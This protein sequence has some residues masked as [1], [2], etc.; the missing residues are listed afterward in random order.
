MK[1]FKIIFF[2]LAFVLCGVVNSFGQ[3]SDPDDPPG[4][5]DDPVTNVP[6][7]LGAFAVLIGGTI[8]GVKSLKKTKKDKNKA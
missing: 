3:P 7:D 6:I 1:K 8:Y 2:V 5:D 4:G